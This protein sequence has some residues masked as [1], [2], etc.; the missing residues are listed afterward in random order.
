MKGCRSHRVKVGPFEALLSFRTKAGLSRRAK[1]AAQAMR[2]EMSDPDHPL[3]GTKNREA[4]RRAEAKLKMAN[5]PHC[6]GQLQ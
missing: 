4:W 1:A 2:A 5:C 6:D 3:F